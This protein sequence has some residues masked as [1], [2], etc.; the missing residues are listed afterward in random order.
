MGEVVVVMS[1]CVPRCLLPNPDRQL[2]MRDE[3]R[4]SRRVCVCVCVMPLV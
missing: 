2:D 1:Q 3:Q 4:I